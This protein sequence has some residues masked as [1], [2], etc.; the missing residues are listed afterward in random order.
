MRVT[1]TGAK[2]LDRKL[3]DLAPKLSKKIVR[4]SLR[5]AAKP[6]QA[7]AKTIVPVRTGFLKKAIKVRAMRRS[8]VRM[9]VRAT[10]EDRTFQDAFYGKWVEL[11]KHD[12]PGQHFMKRAAD[13]TFPQSLQILTDEIRRGISEATK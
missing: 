5:K 9:G 1:V 6:V 10:L 7:R 13:L 11:G 2:E 12:S 4:S 3:R 8:R